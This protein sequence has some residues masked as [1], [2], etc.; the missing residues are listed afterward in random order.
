MSE[1]YREDLLFADADVLSQGFS[2]AERLSTE[3]LSQ[4]VEALILLE[5]E[6]P[7]TV[8]MDTSL[9][10]KILDKCGMTCTFCHNEGTPVASSRREGNVLL[11]N[12]TYRGGRVSVFEQSNGVD[13]VPGIMEPDEAFSASLEKMRLS[14]G[15]TELHLTGGEPTL[16]RSLPNLISNARRAGFSVKMTSNGENGARTLKECAEA[17]LEKVN[18]SIFGTT[19][20]ELAEVQHEKYNNVKLAEVKLNALRHSIDTAL[21]H[22][23]KVDANIVMSDASHAERVKRIINEYDDRV[24]IR[25]L[26][27]LDAGDASYISIYELMSELDAVPVQL[28]VEAGSSNSR[29]K[30]LLPDGRAIY[31]KQIRRTTLPETCTDCSLNN[32][33]DCKEGYYGV[34][35]YIDAQGSYKVG[36]CL[37]RM[38]LTMDIDNFVT[39][40][41]AQEVNMLRMNEFEQLT[42][43]YASRIAGYGEVDNE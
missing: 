21:E 29:V 19:P 40:P 34:R 1:L 43:H 9:R 31:F 11:P 8:G 7:V 10:P 39:S 16:H 24:S 18:F 3:G 27:D 4:D 14:I 26:N 5:R 15:A 37:Q 30:Y 28:Y 33:I 38:D 32:D 20:Q 13:F 36:V 12:P 41:I 42:N 35:L 2:V 22:G 17:G 25:I 6:I 23:I